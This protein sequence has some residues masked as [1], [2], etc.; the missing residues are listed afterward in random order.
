[1]EPLV[2]AESCVYRLA[3]RLMLRAAVASSLLLPAMAQVA[4]GTC[5]SVVDGLLRVPVAPLLY[6]VALVL[7][8]DHFD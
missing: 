4:E 1:M 3:A 6:L 7:I 5:L 8:V 2:L